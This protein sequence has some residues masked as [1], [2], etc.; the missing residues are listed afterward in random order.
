MH[1]PLVHIYTMKI[2]MNANEKFEAVKAA[3]VG[4]KET[5]LRFRDQGDKEGLQFTAD[6]WSARAE[7]YSATLAMIREIES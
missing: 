2:E 4:W 6:Y 5:A 3:L 1:K 7:A